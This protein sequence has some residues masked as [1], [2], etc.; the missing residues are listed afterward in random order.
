MAAILLAAAN[1]VPSI[2]AVR[3]HAPG[4][5]WEKRVGGTARRPSPA[6]KCA[7]R[8][9]RW[10]GWRHRGLVRRRRTRWVFATWHDPR[11]LPRRSRGSPRGRARPRFLH[12]ASRRPTFITL[13]CAAE[14]TR[15]LADARRLALCRRARSSTNLSR[16]PSSRGSVAVA[17][18][19]GSSSQRLLLPQ[20]PASRAARIRGAA[21]PGRFPPRRRSRRIAAMV[22]ASCGLPRGVTVRNAF[23]PVRGDA[24]RLALPRVQRQR[25][26]AQ[27]SDDFVSDGSERSQH[28]KM[29]T[30]QG[31]WP[32][33][34]RPRQRGVGES[35]RTHPDRRRAL[36]RRLPPPQEPARDERARPPARRDRRVNDA[37]RA[38]QRAAR[39]ARASARSRSCR[40]PPRARCRGAAPLKE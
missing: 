20:P 17:V 8:R 9:S 5:Y 33:P 1:S 12:S 23:I 4:P 22:I 21:A 31:R 35:P 37:S 7:E 29:V 18:G 11:P 16:G 40:L 28:P 30:V 38:P 13:T 3:A 34:S 10:T 36:V 25:E 27:H 15:H 26:R 14:T 39:Y 2:D 32:T 19:D 6:W 24:S